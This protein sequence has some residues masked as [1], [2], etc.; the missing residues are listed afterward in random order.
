MQDPK[1]MEYFNF[2]EADLQA[3]RTGNF[4]ETQKKKISAN[5][6]ES[7]HSDV[8]ITGCTAPLAL[9]LLGWMF[10]LIIKDVVGGDN[11]NLGLVINLGIW[12]FITLVVAVLAFRAMFVRHQF[13]LARV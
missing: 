7:F 10:Y 2:T 9:G 3:N 13:R 4:S 12:G 1:L 11:S 6:K 5:Q 8:W